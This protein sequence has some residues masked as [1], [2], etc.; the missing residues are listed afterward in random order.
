MKYRKHS[1]L[2]RVLY[3]L[4]AMAGYFYIYFRKKDIS[5]SVILCYHGI[6]QT[7]KSIFEWQIKHAA[8]YAIQISTDTK[9]VNICPQKKYVCF[10]FDDAFANLLDNAL[11]V[12]EK[13][14]IPAT[15]FAVPGNL[16]ETPCWKMS[17]NHPESYE[18]TM[19]ADQLAS[20]SKHPLIKI[21]SH[22]VT[23][24]NLVEISPEQ[25]IAELADSK[26]QLEAL[27]GCSVEELA[28][29]H[30]A[31]NEAVLAMAQEA[32]YK[33]IYTLD[34]KPVDIE[35]SGAVLGRFSMSPDVWKIEFMLTCTGA[36]AWLRPWR[37]FIRQVRG[38]IYRFRN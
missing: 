20:L 19:T 22:T 7:A 6:P 12:L 29:P 15:V 27:L 17:A 13:Y 28:L 21:G 38:L 9:Q 2:I 18:K 5:S 24:P 30:G 33:R 26:Q 23:H 36:Y 31:Y 8:S 1:T 14:C 11:P 25:A 32:G 10:T 3:L 34:P 16:G 37:R 35:Y 4:I